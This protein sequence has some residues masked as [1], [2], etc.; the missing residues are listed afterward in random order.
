MIS[1]SNSWLCI[2]VEYE[3]GKFKEARKC[4]YIFIIS[5]EGGGGVS[6]LMDRRGGWCHFSSRS[7]TQKFNFHIKILPKYLFYKILCLLFHQG[8]LC[9]T[10]DLSRKNG[11]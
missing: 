10:A 9:V 5:L 7:G 6:E 11:Q 3:T 2:K 4:H 1:D 8:K